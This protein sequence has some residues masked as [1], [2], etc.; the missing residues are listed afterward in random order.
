MS[1]HDLK[2]CVFIWAYI[3]CGQLKVKGAWS[4]VNVKHSLF[5][6]ASKNGVAHLY[7]AVLQYKAKF[8]LIRVLK[9]LLIRA[10]RGAGSHDSHISAIIS[11]IQEPLCADL[12]LL[13]PLQSKAVTYKHNVART[14]G[15]LIE[16]VS[17]GLFI[18]ST[19]AFRAILHTSELG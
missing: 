11:E 8:T 15:S 17:D 1:W 13:K 10:G 16:G 4:N 2:Q 6:E 7:A 12:V 18:P 9:G 19:C 3:V 5:K 14:F